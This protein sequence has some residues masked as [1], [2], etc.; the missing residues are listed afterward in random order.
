[1]NILQCIGKTPVV[2]LKRL[3]RSGGHRVWLKLEMLNPG[4][5]IKDRIGLAMIEDAE[6]RGIIRPGYTIIEPTSGNTGIALAMV[7]AF[8]GYSCIIVMPENMSVE[9]RLLM[10][11]YGARVVLTDAAAGIKGAIDR[12]N[13]LHHKIDG[14][15]IPMQFDNQANVK[16]HME[17]TAIE[18]LQD[19]KDG[20][21]IL[22][23]GVGSGGHI[24]GVG[25]VLKQYFPNMQV[26]AVEPASS[27]VLSGNEPGKHII[28]G[29]GAGFVPSILDLSIIDH[30]IKVD[31]EQAL[32]MTRLL[33]QIEGISAG[34]STGAVLY[35]VKQCLMNAQSERLNVVTF[36][37]DRGERYLSMF[38]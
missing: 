29:I 2:E 32:L 5:S 38:V 21:D 31:D 3:F 35:A 13:E 7:A 30:I 18:L 15:W 23:C 28:Q 33:S 26:V 4:G 37:Y 6:L 22:V 10:Q 24:T 17:T 16:I 36:G 20:I 12:A 19:L 8:K 34:I 27:A 25:R 9:R 1:M 14:S 11:S